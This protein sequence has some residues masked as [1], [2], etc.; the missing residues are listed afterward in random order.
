MSFHPMMFT[1]ECVSFWF[2]ILAE[3]AKRY[4]SIFYRLPNFPFCVHLYFS[5]YALREIPIFQLDTD[6]VYSFTRWL[7]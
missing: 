1:L 3:W 5:I 7:R 4:L 6:A 2:P